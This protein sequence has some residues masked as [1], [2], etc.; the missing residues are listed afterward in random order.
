MF[1]YFK[2]KAKETEYNILNITTL[3]KI[4]KERN[5]LNSKINIFYR[6]TIKAN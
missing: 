1:C 4:F 6:N 5:T 2:S 3:E